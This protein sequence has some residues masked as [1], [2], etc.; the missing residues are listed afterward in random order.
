[1]GSKIWM[2]IEAV[3]AA[4]AA[5]FTVQE[6][7]SLVSP[8]TGARRKGRPAKPKAAYWLP[9]LEP[10]S[11]NSLGSTTSSPTTWTPDCS[12]A[13][14]NSAPWPSRLESWQP[15]ALQPHLA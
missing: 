4:E 2:S 10:G 6:D 3:D 12:P 5:G 15:I 14:H 9:T 7:L 11:V 13:Q 1:M 8:R